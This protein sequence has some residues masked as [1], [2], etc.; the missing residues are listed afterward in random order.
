M[1]KTPPAPPVP[2][3]PPPVESFQELGLSESLLRSIAEV[4][5]EAPTPIQSVAIPPL[6]AGRDLIGQAQTG[7]GKTAAFG[8]ALLQAIDPAERSV[9]ALVL[10][11]TRELGIQV[12]EALHTYGKYLQRLVVLPVYGGQSLEAQQRRLERGVHVVVGTPGRIMD[13]LRRGT[14]RL[15]RIRMVVLDEADEMLRMGFIEDVEWILAQAPP[16]SAGRQTALFSAT[17]PPEIRRI[18]QRHL[19]DPVS[20]ELERKAL[21][22]P[23]IDQRYLIVPQPQKLEALT[24]LLETEAIEAVLVFTRTKTAAAEISEKL[25]ARGYSVAALHGDMNQ[26]MRERV[27]ERL[28]AGQVEIVVATDVAA[29]G[30]DVDRISHVVNYDIPYDLG[31]Y[32]HRI[33]RTGRAGRAGSAVLFVTPRE[34]RMLQDLER[35]TGQRIKPMRMPT[36]A[37]VALRRSEMFKETLRQ[38]ITEQ[39]LDLYLALVEELVEEG[40]DLAVVAAAAAYL[41]RRE[42]PL[43]MAVEPEAAGLSSADG[44]MVRLF[45]NAGRIAGVRPADIVGAIANEAG[46]PGKEIGSI[47]ID[48]RFSLVEVPARYHRQIV[49][50]MSGAT[51]RGRP[52][53]IRVAGEGEDRPRP[54]RRP[55]PGPRGGGR[56]GPA[57]RGGPHGPRKGP[58]PKRSRWP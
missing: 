35:Y 54:S 3:P 9:Q 24:R 13:H 58:G 33:G 39:D 7:T 34:R 11:P 25:E 31:A 12:A 49:E 36:A 47:D 10:T 20:I 14:L 1:K 23:A 28:R 21:N 43:E 50:R 19:H 56:P 6:L 2:D 53:E 5:Y 32:I 57:D 4:G 16:P 30:I 17:M 18:A 38:T 46:V 27:V 41:A 22:V 48:D 44:G 26:P 37:D 55:G 8:L 40:L 42:R 52:L 45:L 15:D 29:R 51:L